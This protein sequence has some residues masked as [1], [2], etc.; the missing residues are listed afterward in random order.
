[1]VLLSIPRD[2]WVKPSGLWPMKIN[3]VYS[4]AK[5][6]AL[7]T[8]PNDAGAA[9]TAGVD[10]IE[11]TV[12]EYMG[13]K[14]NYYA[15]V[16]FRAFEK[17]VNIVGGITVNLDEPYSDPTMLVNG[18]YFSL[19]AGDNKL[20]GTDALA[21]ARSRY[22]T[23]RGDLDRGQHQQEVILAIKDKALSVGTFANPLKISQLLDTF[24]NRVQTN[25]S[26]DD[27]RKLY[28]LS[29]QINESNTKNVDLGQEGE[30]VVTTGTIGDQ[31]VVYP[32]AGVDDYSEVKKFVRKQLKDGFI[33]KENPSIIVLNG[34]S[35]AGLA[36]KRANELKSYGYNVIQVA[37]SSKK[38][39]YANQFIDLTKGQKPYTKR[40][41]ELRFGTQATEKL[42]GFDSSVYVADYIIIVG[43]Q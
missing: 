22:G 4:S 42:D 41:L 17:A 29:K 24:G 3:A 37:D 40:Y 2:L 10:A 23:L 6:Q 30:S 27:M 31:S 18:R 21:Y 26:V 11:K 20:N 34:T 36:N 9:E 35:V 28:E 15:M 39:Y 33:I 12:E 7:Y 38:D 16:D 25:F 13:V 14:I 32:K 5:G 43:E 8:N 19:K 1:V